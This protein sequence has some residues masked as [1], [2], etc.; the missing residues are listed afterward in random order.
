MGRLSYLLPLSAVVLLAADIPSWTS[1]PVTQWD[2]DDARQVLEASPWAKIV[3]V[4]QVRNLSPD[5]RRDSGDWDAGI[6]PSIG[7]EGTGVFGPELEAEAIARA[8]QRQDHGSVIVRW[9]S[10]PVRAAE[11]KLGLTNPVEGA[12][13]YY[14]ILVYNIAT[15]TRWNTANELK[16]I[17]FLKRDKKKDLKPVRV[18]IRQRPDGKANVMYLFRRSDEITRKDRNLRFVAQIGR[19]FVS[20]FFFP[21]DMQMDGRLEL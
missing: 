2:D 7:L 15:P 9:E 16:R 6:G 19:L 21:E 20:Q 13:S 10:S 14:A 18:E 11:F 12:D 8:H 5:E 3:E 4:Q 17:A 1:K